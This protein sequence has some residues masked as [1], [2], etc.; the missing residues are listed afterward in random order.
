MDH[1]RTTITGGRID[2]PDAPYDGVIFEDY[3]ADKQRGSDSGFHSHWSLSSKSDT[4]YATQ[5]KMK[6]N[7]SRPY[8]DLGVLIG[9]LRDIPNLLRRAGGSLIRRYG[10]ANL[11]YEFGI[12]PLVSDIRK[13]VQFQGVTDSR[14]K[15]LN[16]LR[17]KGLRKT[18]VLD[19]L[20]KTGRLNELVQSYGIRVTT[21][22]DYT[23]KCTVKGHARWVP[24]TVLPQTHDGMRRIANRALYGLTVDFSTA[25]E[26][27]PWSWLID[28][29]SNTGDFLAANRNSVGA[30]MTKCAIMRHTIT[31]AISESVSS[32]GTY[33]WTI[34]P[35]YNKYETRYR[36]QVSPGIS[37]SIPFLSGRQLGI[38]ASI[39][40]TRR[41]RSS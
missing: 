7:P 14:I 18:I 21:P 30:S 28:W 24:T 32:T 22:I 13:L 19:R 35:I 37:A 39:G 34:S 6:T 8:V 38:L 36:R 31:H 17:D 26:L 11:T 41:S 20:S 9:E 3:T 40:V 12:K 33:P 27:M 16:I 29:C 1:T 10:S 25:W 5:L 2:R 23:T 15:E 4:E